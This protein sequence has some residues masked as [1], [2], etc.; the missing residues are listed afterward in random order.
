[1][2]LGELEDTLFFERKRKPNEVSG[3][4]CHSLYSGEVLVILVS[5][6]ACF[7]WCSIDSVCSFE[8]GNL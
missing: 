6:E 2:G 8:E 5:F 3:R 4:H 1:M 7:A